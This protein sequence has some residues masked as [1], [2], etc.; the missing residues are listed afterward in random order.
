MVD[1]E[2]QPGAT[3]KM[4]EKGVVKM[5]ASRRTRKTRKFESWNQLPRMGQ[6]QALMIQAFEAGED[7]VSVPVTR[8]AGN[9]LAKTY[10]EA[11]AA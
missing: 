8:E 6:V 2:V 4:N 9:E 5:A 10:R 1:F 3:G 7:F 11:K